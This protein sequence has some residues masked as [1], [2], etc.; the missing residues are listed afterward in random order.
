MRILVDED[1]AV[2]LIQ[3]LRHLLPRH[4]VEHVSEVSWKGKKDR[5]VLPDAARAGYHVFITRDRSQLSDPRECDEIKKSGLHH[6]RYTQRQ[7]GMR[8]LAVA[9]GSVIAALPLMMEELE[10]AEGQRLVR[11]ASIEPRDRFRMIDP[12]RESPSPYWPRL[13]SRRLLGGGAAKPARRGPVRYLYSA[14]LESVDE[15]SHKMAAAIGTPVV[16]LA[17]S[18]IALGAPAV[19]ARRAEPLR[20]CSSGPQGAY[21]FRPVLKA[22]AG[23]QVSG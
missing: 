20:A 19:H 2:Q 9:I 17:F 3:P 21:D 12:R 5:Q 7:E 1:T 11:I 16:T 6:V 15:H 14:T 10:E 23:R 4:Q 18:A 13:G 22:L 8:G